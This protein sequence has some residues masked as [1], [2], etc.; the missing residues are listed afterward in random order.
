MTVRAQPDP[1]RPPHDDD[2]C[3]E[4]DV[5]YLDCF[6]RSGARSK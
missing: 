5:E 1:D 3:A 6:S 4:E 2:D